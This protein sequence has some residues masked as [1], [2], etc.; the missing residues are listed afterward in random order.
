MN[1]Y[2]LPG[3]GQLNPDSLNQDYDGEISLKGK[4]VSMD[5]WFANGKTDLIT[6]D[7]MKEFIENLVKYDDIARKEQKK[8]FD[9]GGTVREYVDHH[10]DLNEDDTEK[11]ITKKQNDFL[12]EV[13]LK[14]VGFYPDEDDHFVIF[15]Y[16]IDQDL[17]DYLIVVHFQKSGHFL[18]LTMES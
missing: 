17:T 6:L 10:L 13:H 14:R 5:I 18:S 15:D 4:T 1:N 8:D 3:F 7:R 16:T 11:D 2:N 9:D 12:D